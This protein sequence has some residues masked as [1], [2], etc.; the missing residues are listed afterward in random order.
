M[1]CRV[2]RWNTAQ[3]SH[4]SDFVKFQERQG[5]ST[6]DAARRARAVDGYQTEIVVTKTPTGCPKARRSTLNRGEDYATWAASLPCAST[7]AAW[8]RRVEKL[9]STSTRQPELP[10]ASCRRPAAT[11]FP[12]RTSD[13]PSAW[14]SSGARSA[15]TRTARTTT[16]SMC[17][18]EVGP[19]QRRRLDEPKGDFPQRI[20]WP[21][22]R[23]ADHA[24]ATAERSTTFSSVERP[25]PHHH[26]QLDVLRAPTP[27][28]C[29]ADG[30]GLDGFPRPQRRVAF[31]GQQEEQANE[32]VFVARPLLALFLIVSRSSWPSSTPSP[33][34]SSSD[35]A[36]S[37]A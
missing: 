4:R 6:R 28:D 9:K 24:V 16:P 32:L 34:R 15:P 3:G 7:C 11:G 8:F 2:R 5:Q 22:Q 21:N 20:R 13:S 26:P 1:T 18:L 17:V 10:M 33:P 35:S 23:S 36:C 27:R 37:S 25:R 14:P 31:T 12:R 29:C 19:Q 30:N